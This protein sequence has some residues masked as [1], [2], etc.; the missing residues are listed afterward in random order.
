MTLEYLGAVDFLVGE[1]SR[2]SEQAHHGRV[3]INLNDPAA[4]ASLWQGTAV[5]KLMRQQA[6]HQPL[7]AVEVRPVA[8]ARVA[9]GAIPPEHPAY[10]PLTGTLTRLVGDDEGGVHG[11]E[12]AF[13]EVLG[14]ELNDALQGMNRWGDPRQAHAAA[15]TLHDSDAAMALIHSPGQIDTHEHAVRC[16]TALIRRSP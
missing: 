6:P 16:R 1:D 14:D 10:L 11:Y 15:A 2:K 9:G 8:I 12:H 4:A 7:A 13:V 3:G 5:R